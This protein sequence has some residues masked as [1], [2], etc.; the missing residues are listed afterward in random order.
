MSGAPYII[1]RAVKLQLESDMAAAGRA[2]N[3]IPGV[4]SGAIGLTPDCVKQ[5][6]EYRRARL[7]YD[8][9][10]ATLRD[11]AKAF[12]RQHGKQYRAD[13][14]REREARAAVTRASLAAE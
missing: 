7:A 5:S 11:Y 3:A 6:P 10:A 9:A 4:G 1:A 13:L 14:L 2:W 8:S 12:M